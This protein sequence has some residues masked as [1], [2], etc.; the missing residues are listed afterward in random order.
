MR[1]DFFS[2]LRWNRHIPCVQCE[3]ETAYF[4]S[5]PSA[6]AQTFSSLGSNSLYYSY[7]PYDFLSL[8]VLL[9][10]F[11]FRNVFSKIFRDF[12]FITF[13]S[14]IFVQNFLQVFF[15]TKTPFFLKWLYRNIKKSEYF[16][17]FFFKIFFQTFFSKFFFQHFFQNF[18]FKIFFFKIYAISKNRNIL[19]FFFKIFFPKFFF[20]ISFQ[21]FFS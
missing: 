5:M 19:P 16:F 13:Y 9:S 7:Y 17:P 3:R 18:F 8:R 11:L 4:E 10:I 1:S 21:H 6:H 12:F 15:V 20:L 2:R 14:K